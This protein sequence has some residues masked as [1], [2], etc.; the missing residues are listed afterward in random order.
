M[1]DADKVKEFWEKRGE[2]LGSVAF[3]S[4]V[5]LEED[6]DAL[7]EKI[8]VETKNVFDYLGDITGKSMVDLGAGIGQWSFRFHDMGAAH[9]TAVEYAESLVDIGRAE[10]ERR[11]IETIEFVASPAEQ[12]VSDR[13]YDFIYISGL[14][15]YLNDDQTG[16][17]MAN[18]PKLL[19]EG[20]VV[21]L[22]DGTGVP[23]RH[24]INQQMSDHLGSE[25]SAIYRT[26]EDYI[27]LFAT[28][29]M[30]SVRDKN[31]FPEG[32]PLNKYPETRLRLY[33]FE[34]A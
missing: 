26:K 16:A 8:R 24:E 29:G 9:V 15:V 6:P 34:K 21:L 7:A 18:L 33:R 14:Y 1:I 2:K 22:R 10:A 4:I 23:D 20:S 5:N 19:H 12:F 27:D 3:E 32:H 30:K 11:D 25:Y 17:L 31:M 13:T 28:I